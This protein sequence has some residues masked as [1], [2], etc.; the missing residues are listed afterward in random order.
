MGSVPAGLARCLRCRHVYPWRV[1]FPGGV[2]PPVPPC[3]WGVAA[4]VA[5]WWTCVWPHLG[6]ELWVRGPSVRVR[7]R[8][9]DPLTQSFRATYAPPAPPPHTHTHRP[10]CPRS[11]VSDGQPVGFQTAWGVEAASRLS[12][13]DR[14]ASIILS[15]MRNATEKRIMYRYFFLR[16]HWS[17]WELDK[18]CKKVF[19]RH[20]CGW[21]K[22]D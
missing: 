8:Q 14:S 12:F 15:N 3:L 10:P 2:S 7:G 16:Q 19:L 21:Q 20:R 18:Y 13:F 5:A 6:C 9:V 1:T 22:H 17:H 11:D 4:A